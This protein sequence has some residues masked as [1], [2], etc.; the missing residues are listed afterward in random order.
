MAK[1]DKH[2]KAL[3]IEPIDFMR[4]NMNEDELKGF[5]KGNIV[6]YVFRKKGQEATDAKK[7]QSYARWL[8]LVYD[9]SQID[10][11]R[12]LSNLI[13]QIKACGVNFK[14]VVSKG[15]GGAYVAAKVAYAIDAD[16][17]IA[18]KFGYLPSQ[19]VSNL[20]SSIFIDDIEDTSATIKEAKQFFSYTG[21]LVQKSL[22][23]NN[24]ADFV[25]CKTKYED[26]INFTFQEV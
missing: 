16:L 12:A 15:R 4:A 3:S 24:L 22:F 8:E 10:E 11:N 26:Y 13:N 7:I 18:S 17:S 9:K 20:S 25:G 6:K 19:L 14:H 23:S 5:Y 2:Y 21:V 1:I